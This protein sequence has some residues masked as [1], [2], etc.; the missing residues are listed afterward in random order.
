MRKL[1]FVFCLLAVSAT[2]VYSQGLRSGGVSLYAI[3]SNGERVPLKAT[4]SGALE[5]TATIS[6]DV[7]LNESSLAVV[8]NGD[9]WII[10]QDGSGNVHLTGS[11]VNV[12]TDTELQNLQTT[13]N[14]VLTRE[15][16][17]SGDTI[18]NT[19]NTL[20]TYEQFP[21]RSIFNETTGETLIITTEGEAKIEPPIVS[22]SNGYTNVSIAPGN[23]QTVSFGSSVYRVAFNST[24]ASSYRYELNST[25]A[26]TNSMPVFQGQ[27]IEKTNGNYTQITFYNPTT[28]TEN[29]TITVEPEF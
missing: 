11:D 13:L 7:Q 26:D 23:S 21:Q 12:A 10:R 15:I 17:A 25:S 16:Q 6:G 3:D 1:L 18:G 4:S 24:G 28:S 22:P 20:H 2:T 8:Q 14:S 19:G 9:T 29:A 5:S 27:Y